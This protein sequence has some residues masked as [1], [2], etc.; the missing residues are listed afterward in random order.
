M[1]IGFPVIVTIDSATGDSGP[2]PT[3]VTD[4]TVGAGATLEIVD[5]GLLTVSNILDVVGTVEVLDPGTPTL[6]LDGPV[7]VETSGTI[8]AIGS[9]AA[10]YFA[11]ATPPPA[12]SYTVDN[13]GVISADSSA[14]LFFEQAATGDRSLRKRSE[15]VALRRGELEHVG[16]P[17]GSP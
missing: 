8:E 2:T 12:G 5:G 16:S 13:N 7:T 10:I 1:T 17:S 15:W 3:A 11:D 6:T 4:L 9:A 14:T